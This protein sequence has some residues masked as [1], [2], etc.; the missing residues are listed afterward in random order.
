MKALS[1]AAARW[2]SA[3]AGR[4]SFLLILFTLSRLIFLVLRIR[5]LLGSTKYY[6]YLHFL[7]IARLS[8]QGLYPCI[9]YWVEYP[10]IFPW[11]SVGLYRLAVMIGSHSEGLVEA[12][13]YLSTASLRVAGEIGTFVLVYRIARLLRGSLAAGYSCLLY[14]ACFI[15]Y[16]LW[17]GAFDTLPTFV[18]LCSLYYFITNRKRLSAVT[19]A[20][21]FFT[22]IFPVVILP[23]AICS[24][25][26][27]SK[28][29]KYMA[30]FMATIVLMLSPWFFLDHTMLIGSFRNILHRGAWETIWALLAGNFASGGV[31]PVNM[32]FA[33]PAAIS[34][35]AQTISGFSLMVI[36]GISCITFCCFFKGSQDMHRITAATAFVLQLFLIF[37]K[38][39]SPQFLTWIAPLIAILFPNKRGVLSLCLLGSANLVEYPLYFSFFPHQHG[40]LMLAVALRTSVLIVTA[41]DCLQL[42][43]GRGD[44]G[45][46]GSPV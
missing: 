37:S 34:G 29:S 4:F 17:N 10:P 32:R 21:G 16:Y 30:I 28:R 22:K 18:L 39:Y 7:T 5:L 38:G 35:G 11:V 43:L 31:V 23:V 8:D 9:D 24:L 20:V 44:H 3:L 33:V 40:W 45:L 1:R 2:I 26:D 25:S 41:I 6:D 19:A 13:Y 14:M 46:T 36:F 15:P 27:W 12:L 42:A